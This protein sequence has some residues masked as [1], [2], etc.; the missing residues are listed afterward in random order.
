M[1][2]PQP[3]RFSEHANWLIPDCLMVGP[4][5]RSGEMLTSVRG[6]YPYISPVYCPSPEE[7]KDLLRGLLQ[8]GASRDVIKLL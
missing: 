1:V 4:L 8:A 5:L 2:L 3:H 7:A 6:R